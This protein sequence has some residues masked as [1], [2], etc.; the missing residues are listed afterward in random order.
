MKIENAS[1]AIIV[2]IENKILLQLRDN[3]KSIFFP[4]CWGLFGGAISKKETPLCGLKREIKEEIN[5][6]LNQIDCKIKKIGN[7]C[8]NFPEYEFKNI[9]RW[10]YV[11][12]LL[13]N[14]LKIKL[15]E[16]S[17]FRFFSK[18]EVFKI[19]KIVPYDKFLISI[20]FNEYK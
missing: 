1:A 8:F 17:D 10:Y 19:S 7:L 18:E 3:K 5:F 16:G 14:N 9:F 13:D 6:D 20:Y 2:N 11:I 4:N 15:G 12:K